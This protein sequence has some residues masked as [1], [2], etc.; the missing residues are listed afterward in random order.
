MEK[1][2]EKLIFEKS[3]EGRKAYS[4]P[5]LD[6]PKSEGLPEKFLRK[7][8]A[9]LPETSEIEVARHF[10]HL[11]HQ[12]FNIEG[13]FYPLGSCTMKYNPKINEKTAALPGFASAHPLTKDEF[14]QGSLQLMYEL[15]EMLKEITGL[16]GVSLQP[17]AGSQGELTGIYM[18]KAYHESR[19]DDARTTILVP[20]SS[21]GTNPASA[22][23][24]G[25]KVDTIKTNETGR[26]DLEHLKSRLGN[27]IAGFM[28][29]N[30]STVGLFES[31]ILEVQKLVNEVGGLMYMDG[32]NFN[33]LLT[34]A[35]PGDMGFDCV[36]INLHKT[37]STPHG[38]G[39]PGAGPVCV[40]ERLRPFLPVPQVRLMDGEY[41]LEFDRAETIGKLHTF[42]GNFGVLVRAYTYMR[43]LG[44]EGMRAVSENAIINANYLFRKIQDYFD[45]PFDDHCM[46]EFIISG[47][48][49]KRESG[50]STKDIGKRLL[51]YGFHAPTVYFPLNVPEAMLIEPTETENRQNLD[52]FADAM[53][54]IANECEHV[55]EQVLDAPHSTELKRLDE[56]KAAR[57]LNIC[58]IGY[59]DP[60]TN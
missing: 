13:G 32:A 60:S 4:L 8:P 36:H 12:N 14:S 55:P 3:V 50:V 30:P 48:R 18:F 44:K 39:G 53:I 26:I 17:A 19:N 1:L 33:A 22:A 47:S 57:F 52:A 23:I 24:A 40:S 28:V 37:F 54:S 11:A 43:M 42:N 20:D 15:G 41:S 56:A 45:V 31:D 58:W 49:Q 10:Q 29:T 46:H 27:H 59:Q 9:R 5:K 35:R 25:Y 16:Q 6:V 38:G 21:H 51:D 34:L 7:E 2:T